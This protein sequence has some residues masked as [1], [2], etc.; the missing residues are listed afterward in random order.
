MG[1]SGHFPDWVP[2]DD[3]YL[4]SAASLWSE[5]RGT[6]IR[7]S[8]PRPRVRM[9][10]DSGGFTFFSRWGDYPFSRDEYMGL[11][12]HYDPLL[13]ASL[14][15]PCE[16]GVCRSHN[17]TN[18][19]RIERT[20]DNLAYFST[21]QKWGMI[22]VVQGYTL[23][24]RRY[25]VREML[26]RGLAR[27]YMALGSLCILRSPREIDN[28]IW[29]LSL[30]CETGGLSPKWH[31][32]GVKLDYFKL[33]NALGMPWVWSFDTAAWSIG[34][35]NESRNAQGQEELARRYH[36]Y[37][38]RVSSAQVREGPHNLTLAMV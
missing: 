9:F 22:P 35:S 30:E 26:R 3:F 16:P 20:L 27:E 10:L 32:L 36:R 6:F 33:K 5:E 19:D 38:R 13:W 31:L 12:E 18:Y 14:D 21:R 11:V 28:I 34:L 17:Q 4:I 2:T 7:R 23:D 8:Y 15:Y 29:Q 25:C 37:V 24:E 1:F